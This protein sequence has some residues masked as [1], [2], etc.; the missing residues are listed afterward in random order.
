MRRLLAASLGLLTVA[1]C[2]AFVGLDG[3]NVPDEGGTKSEGGTDATTDTGVTMEAAPDSPPMPKCPS[4]RGSAMVQIDDQ[5]CID[6]LEA[7]E[8]DYATFVGSLDGGVEAASLPPECAFK[9]TFVPDDTRSDKNLP[10]AFVDWCDA[11]AYCK[12]AGKELCG[13]TMGQTIFLNDYSDPTKST[14]M[15]ACTQNGMKKLPY[16]TYMSSTCRLTYDPDGG[17]D[18][19]PVVSGSMKK[20]EGGYPGVFDMVGNI[21]EWENACN[22]TTGAS[23][24][25]RRRGGGFNELDD[26]STDCAYDETDTRNFRSYTSGIRC[27]AKPQ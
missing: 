13:G 3:L 11:W 4:G 14:W 17:T 18:M 27:C 20:C 10:V 1:A 8:T 9:T 5:H 21:K 24:I 16:G 23:D 7:N 19:G 22:G 26:P 15:S 2:S 12:W 25:C 6:A